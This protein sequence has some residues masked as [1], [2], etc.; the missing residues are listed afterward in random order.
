MELLEGET[1]AL[2]LYRA[3]PADAVA[4]A[5]RVGADI[6]SVLAAAHG[7]SVIHRD[8][9]PQNVFVARG[10]DGEVAIK[11]LDFGLAK[12][13]DRKASTVLTQPGG[14]LGTPAYMSPEQCRGR[15]DLD[16]RTDVY[17]FACLLFEMIAGNPPFVREA[18]G[19]FIIAHATETPATLASLG[20]TVPQAFD[21]MIGRM[22][23]KDH[24]LRPRDFAAIK[25]ELDRFGAADR[26]SLAHVLY[27]GATAR[28]RTGRPSK[29]TTVVMNRADET[30]DLHSGAQEIIRETTLSRAAVEVGVTSPGPRAERRAPRVAALAA[31]V[32]LVVGGAMV[33][34]RLLRIHPEV[35][36]TATAAPSFRLPPAPPPPPALAATA[37]ATTPV[38][39]PAAA[40]APTPPP[41]PALP[42]RQLA[43]IV[44]PPA[45]V[46]V[47]VTSAPFDSDVWVRGQ[48][49]EHCRTPCTLSLPTEQ[50][51]VTLIARKPGY[52]DRAKT[53][54]PDRDQK[55]SFHLERQRSATA[56]SPAAAAPAAAPVPV[57]A[58]ADEDP[59]RL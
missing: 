51:Q 6:A 11:V 59:A 2:Y 49:A 42:A 15:A 52:V 50:A 13:I 31:L 18:L 39:A 55:L 38:P 24:R 45:R 46:A 10:A 5:A 12:L 40:P 1:L 23:V 53:I 20:H 58:P 3:R 17:S 26:R 56:S 16:G 34:G 32:L 14:I 57:E 19:D 44:V 4:A 41:A 27:D 35:A 22:L 47:A 21:A 54:V 36:A 29:A 28:V 43:A 33:G 25:A 30:V 8:L 48:P 9:K 7:R 37:T